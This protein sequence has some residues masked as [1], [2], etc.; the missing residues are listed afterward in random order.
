LA[1]VLL[2]QGAKGGRLVTAVAN[3]GPK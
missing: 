1:T 2:V 3:P